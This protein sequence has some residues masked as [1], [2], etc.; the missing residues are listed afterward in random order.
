MKK[1][2]LRGYILIVFILI[3]YIAAIIPFAKTSVF[4]IALAFSLPAFLMQIYTLHVVMRNQAL[5]KDKLYD[6]PIMRIS[7]LYL[8]VQLCISLLLM[9]FAKKIPVFAV[10]IIETVILAA[11]VMGLFAISSARTE[12]VRQDV[13]LKKDLAKMK[14]LQAQVNLLISQCGESQIREI[15][16]RLVEEIRYSN[17]VSGEATEKIEDEITVLQTEIETAA[18][19]GDV[20]NVTEYCDRMTGLLKERDRICKDRK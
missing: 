18:L 6:F 9:G 5:I 17:P 12:A 4:W 10:V 3:I 2:L 16:V 1:K 8:A 11:A 14:E 19:D 20:E 13:Q 15:L 7:A